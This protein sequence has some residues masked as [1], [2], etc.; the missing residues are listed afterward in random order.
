[1][2]KNEET[3]PKFEKRNYEALKKS[4]DFLNVPIKVTGIESII[5]IK[6]IKDNIK[7]LEKE[8]VGIE[9][10]LKID[11]AMMVNVVNN[12]PK[13][14]DLLPKFKD[15]KK[16]KEE[17]ELYLVALYLF[18]RSRDTVKKYESVLKDVNYALAEEAHNLEEIKKQTGID[19]TL[20]INK[21]DLE[22]TNE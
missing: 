18:L 12:H 14:N 8:K 20:V 22:K 17:K 3:K 21:S 4:D 13:I 10:Q 7:T 16:Q 19:H 2:K 6:E 1:M 11:R 5:T 9:G 15:T